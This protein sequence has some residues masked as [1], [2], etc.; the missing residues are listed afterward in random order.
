MLYS[1]LV[2]F[3]NLSI[4]F[5]DILIG[6]K[7]FSNS[8][9]L[10]FIFKTLYFWCLNQ[11]ILMY[12]GKKNIHNFWKKS[13]YVFFKKSKTS[14]FKVIQKILNDFK[15]F[16]II[17][18]HLSKYITSTDYITHMPYVTYMTYI[19][20]MIHITYIIYMSYVTYMNDKVVRVT[21]NTLI[22]ILI[23]KN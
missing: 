19:T 10:F 12:C 5:I 2:L 22:K 1:L 11:F 21:K 13:Y 18:S 23:W 3:P 4:L 7:S 9:M 16:E 8:T 15:Q 17:L 14:I 6:L 20:H